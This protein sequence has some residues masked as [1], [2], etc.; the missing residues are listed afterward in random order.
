[1][2]LEGRLRDLALTEVL[3]LL[4]I[5]RKSGTLHVHAPLEARSVSITISDGMV[6][7]VTGLRDGT[8]DAFQ[9]SYDARRIEEELLTILEWSDGA[10][11]FSAS[12]NGTA[13]ATEG[14]LDGAASGPGVA[15]KGLHVESLLMESARR[16]DAWQKL[17]PLISD[18]TVV[19]E[20]P[21][22]G[23]Q[24][25]SLLHLSPDQW[26]ILTR[27]D[28]KRSLSD[29]A[30]VLEQDVVDVAVTVHGLMEAGVL[31]ARTDDPDPIPGVYSPTGPFGTNAVVG[32]DDSLFDPMR[33]GVM[34]AEGIPVPVTLRPGVTHRAQPVT[35]LAAVQLATGTAADTQDDKSALRRS[36]EPGFSVLL[37]AADDAARNGR[38]AEACLMWEECL[39]AADRGGAVAD[40]VRE[41]LD[42]VRRLQS[43]LGQ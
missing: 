21:D 9:D 26:E 16:S 20:F 31:T 37:S 39:A 35:P 5:G 15:R 1:M 12:G 32:E 10:F 8:S 4:A 34:T 18:A 23:P 25:L 13:S 40:A 30:L 41:R 11:H 28:G 19:P 7:G 6:V 14:G 22:V 27:V 42:V 36:G 3:Q 38:F 24:Q 29:L 17:A 33:T 43:L 2:S